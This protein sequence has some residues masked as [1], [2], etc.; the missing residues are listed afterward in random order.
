M[1]AASLSGSPNAFSLIAFAMIWWIDVNRH[2]RIHE[3]GQ[4][5]IRKMNRDL[6]F[7]AA[8]F[9]FGGGIFFL[10]YFIFVCAL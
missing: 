9:G 3:P 6:G 4:D 5:A 2:R 7:S 10:G 8:V 1:S